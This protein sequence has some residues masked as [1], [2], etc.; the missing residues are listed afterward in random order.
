MW[1]FIWR[2]G[3]YI[4]ISLVGCGGGGGFGY[5][6]LLVLNKLFETPQSTE[7]EKAAILPRDK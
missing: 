7:E 4:R 6:H 5:R 1:A 3:A 2:G